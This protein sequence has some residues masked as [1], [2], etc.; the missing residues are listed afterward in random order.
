MA[1]DDTD[2]L[3][4]TDNRILVLFREWVATMRALPFGASDDEV[5][6]GAARA[7]CQSTDETDRPER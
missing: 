2:K 5:T 6:A 7:P 1:Q 4:T 3:S